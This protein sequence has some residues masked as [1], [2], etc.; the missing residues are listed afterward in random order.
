MSDFSGEYS[1]DMI[2]RRA[3]GESFTP[4][5]GLE[6]LRAFQS[7]PRRADRNAALD[8]VKRIAVQ[9]C[10]PDDEVAIVTKKPRAV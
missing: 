3:R 9:A 7:I 6:L 10:M 2:N 8:I 4:E 5:E 1:N